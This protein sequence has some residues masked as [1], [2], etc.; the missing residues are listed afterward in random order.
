MLEPEVLPEVSNSLRD[1]IIHRPLPAWPGV[2][3]VRH[4]PCQIDCVFT[5]GI[6]GLVV[7]QQY[8]CATCK[9]EVPEAIIFMLQAMNVWERMK[10][11]HH[12]WHFLYQTKVLARHRSRKERYLAD[13]YR[14]VGIDPL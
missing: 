3:S 1:W 13:F 10:A 12:R 5:L 2:W 6:F 14:A 11:Y 9:T 4:A 7:R 8:V